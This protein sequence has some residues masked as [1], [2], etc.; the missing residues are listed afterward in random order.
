MIAAGVR[1]AALMV[2]AAALAVGCG[3]FSATKGQGPQSDGGVARDA[4]TDGVAGAGTGGSTGTG[5][6]V[7]GSGGASSG[8]GGSA[9]GSADA[10]SGPDAP[11]ADAS[12]DGSA[13]CF[14]RLTA[15]SAMSFREEIEVGPMSVFRVRAEVTR[16]GLRPPQWTWRVSDATFAAV[17]TT[18]VGGDPATV[19]FPI[20]TTGNYSVQAEVETGTSCTP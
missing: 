6:T 18:A 11:A 16:P 8:S 9:G 15:L 5:G 14:V 1:A 13:N 2:T 3:S 19:E 12:A 7:G 10:S 20:K 4:A 17:Y